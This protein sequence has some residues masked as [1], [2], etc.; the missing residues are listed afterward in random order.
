MENFTAKK[1]KELYDNGNINECKAYITK[2][3]FPATN[4][5][6][7][8]Y[9]NDS[10]EVVQR[11]VFSSVYLVKFP[12]LVR[13]W[14]IKD[15][16]EV[17]KPVIKIN[18]P[19]IDAQKNEVNLCPR[20]M[21]KTKPYK[22]YDKKT[23]AGVELMLTHI[24]NTQANGNEEAYKYL[25]KWYANMIK[26]NKNES[27]IYNKGEEGIGKSTISEFIADYVIGPALS[28]VTDSEPLSGKFNK[29]LFA[30]L[31][32]V[33]E[34]LPVFSQKEWEGVSSRL[35]KSIT[36]NRASYNEKNE[37]AF[38]A[39]N[40]NNMMINTNV[41]AIQHSEGRRYFI[42]D[43]SNKYKR[44]HV[45]F[46]KLKDVCFN[47]TVGEAF[48]NYMLEL[49]TKNFNSQKDMPENTKKTDAIVDHLDYVYRFLKDEYV[50]AHRNI[51]TKYTDLYQE[52]KQYVNN[53]DRKA[54]SKIQFNAKLVSVG[55]KHYKSNDSLKFNVPLE[56]LNTIAEKNKWLHELDEYRKHEEDNEEEEEKEDIEKM[57][58]SEEN[59]I[60][61][62]K[63]A[64]L[65]AIIKKLQTPTPTAPPSAPATAPPKKKAP[66]KAIEPTA[67]PQKKAS[68]AIEPIDDDDDDFDIDE[69]MDLSI[70][71]KP[72]TVVEMITP[73]KKIELKGSSKIVKK[74]A[75]P[76][77]D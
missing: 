69:E 34:E 39:D 61:K 74:I 70:L 29:S 44:N 50:L 32:V 65:E 27:C 76:Y 49:D 13:K 1:M 9:I 33:F 53:N 24:K 2:Y 51:K 66:T 64:E 46:G 68:K 3:F 47:N 18:G 7:L 4:G 52:Y 40:I 25:I 41:E 30:K 22:E 38:E 62:K 26:G 31:F 14:F 59:K 55:I 35:K 16:V 45:Y 60:M 36:S 17:F 73:V 43:F 5:T 71:K 57:A 28:I 19:L 67:P 75:D 12:D 54:L 48:Y 20:M 56:E 10:I 8:Y 11:D 23:K 72:S 15:Y 37:K 63:I 42:T 77:D 21:H 6:Y 58:L